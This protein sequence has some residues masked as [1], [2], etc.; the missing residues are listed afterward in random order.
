VYKGGGKKGEYRRKTVPVSLFQPNRWGLYQVHGN[1]YE[2][3]E[4]CWNNNFKDAPA[5]GLAWTTGE[6]NRRVVRGGSWHFGAP[7][8]R[9]A[10]RESEDATVR[11]SSTG[12]RVARPVNP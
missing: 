5:D 11:D 4:D 8:L 12:F 9:A 3:V 7:D 6:C 10:F 1:V 2:W